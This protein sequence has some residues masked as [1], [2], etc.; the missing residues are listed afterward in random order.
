MVSRQ[1]AEGV[2]KEQLSLVFLRNFERYALNQANEKF[3]RSLRDNGI[4]LNGRAIRS[5]G[6]V[7]LEVSSQKLAIVRMTGPAG[8]E[9]AEIVGIKGDELIRVLCMSPGSLVVTHGP[10]GQRIGQEFGIRLGD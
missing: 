7:Y 4:G 6:A 5:K 9:L 2:T 3:G 8:I 10:C 1:S